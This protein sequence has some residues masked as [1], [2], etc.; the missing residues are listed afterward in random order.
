MNTEFILKNFRAFDSNG[1]N[2]TLAPLTLLTGCNS[3][4]KSSMVKALLLLNNFFNQMKRDIKISSDCYPTKYKLGVTN[5]HYRLGDFTSVLNRDAKDNQITFSYTIKSQIA[6]EPF[7]V[8]YSFESNKNDTL[9]EGWLSNIAIKNKEGKLFYQIKVEDSQ[10]RVVYCDL[11]L[12]KSSFAQFSIFSLKR[13]LT[14]QIEI[15]HQIPE[16]TGYTIDDIKKFRNIIEH[17][18]PYT[19]DITTEN[20]KDFNEYYLN[21]ET[22]KQSKIYKFS[23]YSQIGDF[24]NTD[25]IYYLPIL[26]ILEGIAKEDVRNVLTHHPSN[27]WNK[28]LE[29]IVSDFEKSK[30]LTFNDYIRYFEESKGLQH[31]G[32]SI[33]FFVNKTHQGLK[34]LINS[35]LSVR[36]YRPFDDIEFEFEPT[37]NLLEGQNIPTKYSNNYTDEEKKQKIEERKEYRR[38]N[39]T[40]LF[41]V[42]TLWDA[43]LKIDKSFKDTYRSK[44]EE[45]DLNGSVHPTF[46]IFA[47]YASSLILDILIPTPVFDQ[48]NYIGSSR[49]DVQRLYNI[50]SNT[51]PFGQ[52]LSEYFIAKRNC[53]DHKKVGKFLK[54][55]I[56]KFDIANSVTFKNVSNGLGIAAYIHSAPMDKKGHLLADEGYGITQLFSILLK[57]E[58]CI[59]TSSQNYHAPCKRNVYRRYDDAVKQTLAPS[60]IAIE[61]PE[62]HLHPRYQSLLAEMFADAYKNYNIHFLIET[63]SEY[64]IRKL[65]TLIAKR[66]IKQD[67]VAIHYISKDTDKKVKSILIK[68]DGRLATAFGSGFFDEADNLA[69]DLLTF[70]VSK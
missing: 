49:V 60:T 13:D 18:N 63:H 47:K 53:K 52:T 44:Y 2:F 25:I 10:L 65:Q 42:Q 64:L 45:M 41:L 48:L 6:T 67:D 21:Q 23:D 68:E 46:N 20:I 38:K 43:S 19:K 36:T 66:E 30:H 4:G 62:I 3:A 14:E 56:K 7:C 33:D 15:Y 28:D 54:K 37:F 16:V 8:E 17:I 58:T 61:E 9:N 50:D 12:L 51:D 5:Y 40:F 24:I 32:W 27:L 70:K 1:E 26:K 39:I 22:K 69:M 59:L 34:E 11:S 29:A 55:W 35:S 31:I 57:I